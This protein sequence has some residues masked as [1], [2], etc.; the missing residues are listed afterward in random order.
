M[1]KIW[2]LVGVFS[3]GIAIG[4]AKA[5]PWNGTNNPKN[6][7]AKYQYRFDA[8]PLKGTLDDAHM[9]WSDN[10]WESDWAGI[11]LRWMNLREQQ[12]DPEGTERL[13]K[14]AQFK[15]SPPTRD[16]IRGMSQADLAKLSPAEKYDLLMGRYD[17]PTLKSERA[18]TSPTRP[19]WDGICHG[20]GPAAIHY[21]EPLPVEVKNPDGVMVPFGSSDVKGLLSYYYA[22]PAYDYARGSRQLLKQGSA[23]FYSPKLDAFDLSQWIA[24]PSFEGTFWSGHQ[25]QPEKLSDGKFCEDPKYSAPYGGI[26]KCLDS[27]SVTGFVEA[28]NVVGQ[29]GARPVKRDLFGV[30]GITD[31]NAGAFHVVMANQ[32]GLMKEG[33]IANIP[34]KVK[35]AEIW[36][37][38]IVGFETRIL[39]YNDRK[40]GDQIEVRTKLTYT[41]EIAQ[42]WEPV[43]NTPKQR[44]A[45]MEFTYTL[46]LDRQGNIVGGE[47]ANRKNHP[48]FVWKHDKIEIRGYFGRINEIYRPRF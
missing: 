27:H 41:S 48:S 33:F 22:V 9:P 40:R 6:M 39:D 43:I 1:L 46:E 37:Q 11:S 21:A 19:D 5:D 7:N 38:P 44:F 20:W 12:L 15:Y 35:N 30:K 36:N 45:T 34:K 47:W 16:E 23:L 42:Q 8:L 10:Y 32:L 31:P 25:V 3:F 13:D 14:Y 2:I 4:W 29:V 26:E 17:F 24:L 18:R 28:L